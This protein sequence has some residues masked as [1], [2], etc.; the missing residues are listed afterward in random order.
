[1]NF[2]ANSNYYYCFTHRQQSASLSK[3]FKIH[4]II[5]YAARLKILFFLLFNASSSFISFK[6]ISSKTVLVQKYN[7]ENMI[8]IMFIYFYVLLTFIKIIMII[9]SL[10]SICIIVVVHSLF[11]IIHFHKVCHFDFLYCL[12]F[13]DSIIKKSIHGES[14]IDFYPL[15]LFTYFIP[16]IC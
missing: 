2:F 3:A 13:N 15:K 7:I 1:M 8:S 14:P 10:V 6:S 5:K 4:S 11:K 12:I 16:F 9:M